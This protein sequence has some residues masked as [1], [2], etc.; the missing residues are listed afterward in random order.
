[1]EA[2]ATRKQPKAGRVASMKQCLVDSWVTHAS[3]HQLLPEKLLVNSQV[4]FAS[5]EVAWQSTTC[6]AS[7]GLEKKREEKRREEKRREEKRR[8][9]KRRE[10]KRREE[11]KRKIKK[12]KQKK[13]DY[14]FWRQLNEKPSNILGCSGSSGPHIQ[15]T[16][17]Q[18]LRLDESA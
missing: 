14:V 16:R 1:M 2:A 6:S 5:P 18:M 11:Q 10:E 15:A 13:M 12:R 8:E 4:E 7:S 3:N 9:E 17:N